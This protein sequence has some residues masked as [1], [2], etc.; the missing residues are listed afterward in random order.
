VEL[1]VLGQR[2]GEEAGV[3]APL[4]LPEA[5]PALLGTCEVQN[6][7]LQLLLTPCPRKEL[8]LLIG[9]L[10][11]TVVTLVVPRHLL[12]RPWRVTALLQKSQVVEEL[13][14]R[15]VVKI[16]SWELRHAL[17]FCLEGKTVHVCVGVRNVVFVVLQSLAVLLKPPLLWKRHW[18]SQLLSHHFKVWLQ[19][20][21]R[22]HMPNIQRVAHLFSRQGAVLRTSFSLRHWVRWRRLL[23]RFYHWPKQRRKLV[24]TWATF[25]KV[26]LQKF[27]LRLALLI[28][29]M[30]INFL[31]LVVFT[32]VQKLLHVKA[33]DWRFR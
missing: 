8:L 16:W 5:Y 18:L 4:L 9:V 25:I 22:L 20:S 15:S 3:D 23:L 32:L 1:T 10:L 12:L 13:L 33:L 30:L 14:L 28:L 2:G 17:G 11:K 29:Y 24:L 7:V 6:S 26:D 19:K 27:L 21:H 31:N